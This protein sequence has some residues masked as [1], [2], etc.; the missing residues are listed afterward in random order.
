MT[1]FVTMFSRLLSAS[2]IGLVIAIV[3]GLQLGYAQSS[4]VVEID[5]SEV[6]RGETITMTIRVNDRQGS[7]PMDVSAFGN[8]FEVIST[9]SSSRLQTVN[10]RVQAWTEYTLVLFPRKLGEQ[11]IPSIVVDE[12]PTDAFHINVLAADD[13]AGASSHPELRMETT[14]SSNEVFVQEQLLFTIRLYYTISGIRNP[15]FTDLDLDNAVVQMLGPPN[16]YEQLIDGTRYGVFEMNYVIFPQ[17][18]GTLEVPDIVFRGQVTDA[19]SRFVFRAT[20]VEPVTAFANGTEVR[21]RERPG[22]YPQNTTWLPSQS[23]TINDEWS[24]NIDRLAP[25]DTIERRITLTAFGLDGPALPPLPAL[26]LENTNVYSD[27]PD[28]RRSV[29][30]GN[31]VGER[32]ESWSIVATD[33]G[34]IAVPEIRLPWW[35]TE[36]ESVEYAVLP[37]RTLVVTGPALR[38]PATPGNGLPLADNL[39]LLPDTAPG[40]LPQQDSL[41]SSPQTPA[42]VMAALAALLAAA[43]VLLLIIYRQRGRQDQQTTHVVEVT[44]PY[45]RS[46][47]DNQESLAFRD[48]QLACKK[49]EAARIRVALIAWARQYYQ[50]PQLHTLDALT[51]RAGDND[52]TMA[53]RALQAALYSN[54]NDAHVETREL[55]T[56]VVNAISA[57][58]IR[59]QDMRRQ[60][61]KQAS[62]SLP[63]LYRTQ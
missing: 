29:V 26:A 22:A 8:D 30:D 4:I 1:G 31:V 2:I 43:A 19:S 10:H 42:W 13:P 11:E 25:G 18:S 41:V 17:R 38:E 21:V 49:R 6:V 33:T 59:E 34:T 55:A 48:L 5:R 39:D 14:I 45:Q 47:A 9:R 62:Y 28:I 44:E 36:T 63:P 58:R 50:D 20:N 56:D 35:N 23:V 52:V 61:K 53:S 32:R 27:R 40:A 54:N 24:D 51:R 12:Q 46:I 7:V 57:L 15:N 60:Q 37:A 3:G 16:Q